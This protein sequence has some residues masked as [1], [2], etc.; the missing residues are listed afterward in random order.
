[1]NGGKR[2]IMKKIMPIMTVLVVGILVLSGVGIAAITNNKVT[3]DNHPPDAPEITGPRFVKPG[4]HEWT[5]KAIDPDGDN[6]SYYIEWGDGDF[7]DWS[8]FFESGEEVT[9]N[10]TFY[11]YGEVT[12]RTRAKDIHGAIG[13]WGTL[14]VTISKSKQIINLPFLQFVGRFIERFLMLE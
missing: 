5:F 14:K 4:T 9:R 12:I 2:N 6:V 13:D 3:M 8:E 1:M 11:K 10:H 7:E